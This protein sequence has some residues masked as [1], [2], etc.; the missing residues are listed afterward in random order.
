MPVEVLTNTIALPNSRKETQ[1][2]VL[3]GIGPRPDIWTVRIFEPQSGPE[4]VIKIEGPNGFKWEQ[5]FFGPEEE[6]PEFIRKAV[7]KAT[8]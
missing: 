4:Y 7:E 8:H 6:A 5:T 1:E 2:A 3:A